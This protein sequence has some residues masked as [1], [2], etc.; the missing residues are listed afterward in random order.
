M[1]V[2]SELRKDNM[3]YAEALAHIGACVE[4]NGKYYGGLVVRCVSVLQN[5]SWRNAA[6]IVRAE[7]PEAS[8]PVAGSRR[9]R[10]VHLLE[11]R[12]ELSQLAR[13]AE[14]MPTGTITVD[15]E[16]V[17]V[18]DHPQFHRWELYPTSN[19]YSDL[20]GYLYQA[21]QASSVYPGQLQEPLVDFALP[22]YSD[23]IHAVPDWVRLCQF[24]EWSDARIGYVCLFLAE[25][26]ARFSELT[27]SGNQL[28]VRVAFGVPELVRK[29]HIQGAWKTDRAHLPISLVV[30]DTVVDTAIPSSAT[31]VDLYLVDET[32][33][34]FDY[35]REAPN[36]TQGLG[37][38]LPLSQRHDELTSVGYEPEDARAPSATAYDIDAVT[39]I[40]TRGYLENAAGEVFEKCQVS[41]L[42]CA[43]IFVDIDDFKSFNDRYGHDVGDRVLR[44]VAEAARRAVD[45]RGGVLG[46]YGGEEIVATMSN[47]TL[48][49]TFS[50]GERIRSTVASLLV[51]G[52][53]VTVSVGVAS[54]V[55]LENISELW[56]RADQALL[57]AKK[58]GKNRVARYGESV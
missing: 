42:P 19:D 58:L 37:R 45:L 5:D 18:G 1:R 17:F 50:L 10:T 28:A 57:R 55:G 9:Y 32:G 31:A 15:G 39:G 56:K 52:L 54:E 22:Y 34:I 3:T 35:H 46:R 2:V 13:L 33:T 21:N 8:V 16:A 36:W 25:C 14:E 6:C 12:L 7:P 51:D 43:A 4:A 24:H 29:L 20:P 47:L 23:V 44:A 40:G 30:V 41:D 53:A 26:R 49:E 11:E 38:V 27:V 48:A